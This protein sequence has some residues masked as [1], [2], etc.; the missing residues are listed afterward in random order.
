MIE[1]VEMRKLDIK[2][3]QAKILELK[4]EVF[5]KKQR[6]IA[7]EEKNIATIKQLK[8]N[9]ARLYTVVQ[10]KLT[11][12]PTDVNAVVLPMAKAEKKVKPK[13]EVKVKIMDAPEVAETT[14]KPKK[15]KITKETKK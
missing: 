12:L 14:E 8:R 1:I 6:I 13:K 4:K 5:E 11:E 7:G 2:E 3:L 15:E 9:I 10:Q